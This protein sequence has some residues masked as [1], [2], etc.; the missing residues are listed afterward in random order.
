MRAV[1]AAIL[2]ACTGFL[3]G[4]ATTPEATASN[5]PFEPLNRAIYH[6][7]E[8]TDKLI[9][10]PVAGFY[11][12]Y[13]PPPL[14]RGLHNVLVNCDLPV[15]F[16]NDLLQGEFTRAGSTL[17]R[18]A[19]NST[20]GLGGLVDVATPAGLPYKPADFGQTLGRYGVPEGPFLVLPVIGPD[21]LRD[22]VGGA[23]DLTFNP[24]LYLP[25]AEP[26]AARLA[27]AAA[28][29]VARPYQEHAREIVLR[30]ELERNSV[31]PYATMR[32][33]Y[34]QL[35]EEEI[36]GYPDEDESPRK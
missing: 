16:A 18:F 4:C 7:D 27:T 13:M 10:L 34:R 29:P 5:D 23:V 20:I 14:R 6:L 26:F 8:R 30:Q 2:A 19:M 35:R 1:G 24:L 25:P 21:P 28:V 15:T 12:F 22:L 11:L 3:G 33:V 36:N 9:V 32:S 31:D 17:G